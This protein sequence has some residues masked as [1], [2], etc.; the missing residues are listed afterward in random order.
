MNAI[1][2]QNFEIPHIMA[3]VAVVGSG[4][5]GYNAADSLYSLG[6]T[7]VI[8]VTEGRMMGTSRNTGSDK[9]TYYKLNL[10]GGV[11]DSVY[12]MAKALMRGGSMHGDIALTDAALSARGFFKL[13]GLGVP[14]PMNEYGEYVGYK[15]D[16]DETTR[17]TSCG[18][19]TSKYMTEALE[20]AIT[21][22][23][24]PIYDRHRVIKILTENG[25]CKGFLTISPELRT[26]KNPHGLCI[27]S[28]G[29]VV[30]AV[31]GPSAIYADTVYPPSQTCSLGA[32]FMAGAAGA[33]LT[34]SQ[35]GLAS[36]KFRWNLSGTYQ[37]VLPRY[38]STDENGGDE[39]EFLMD[40]FETEEEMLHAIFSKGYEWP[41]DPKKT[42]AGGSSRVDLAVFREKQKG[43]RVFLDYTKNPSPADDNGKLKLEKLS[44]KTREYLANSGALNLATPI[45]RL[46]KMNTPAIK[47]YASHGIDLYTEKLEIAVCAQHC[48]GG[49]AVN[50]NREST[51]LQNFYAVG[52]CAGT[53][54]VY[55]P[56]GS[57]LN[58]T[59]TGSLFAA[60]DIAGERVSAEIPSE[61]S[62]EE[63]RRM[64]V[65]LGAMTGGDMTRDEVLAKRL[66]MGRR[67]SDSAAFLRNALKI[68]KAIGEC[69]SEIFRF[70]DAYRVC[71]ED[72]LHDALINLD[73]LETQLVYLC[74]IRDYIMDDGQS[75]GSYLIIEE[76]NPD[77][78][79]L[80]AEIDTVH[81]SYVQN[82]ILSAP[83][84]V[85]SFFEPVRPLPASEQWFETVWNAANRR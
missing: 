82:T 72:A 47:L 30:Y 31:G 48:N 43:R 15:T 53:F 79:A 28:A 34:E 63:L 21:A 9:Q 55:R 4:A 1:S 41:F 75:R 69:K 54:G 66:A 59:Q 78:L 7:D 56:G 49:L 58:S 76:K 25:I 74:A 71:D 81:A 61:N 46:A 37:Q 13:V 70:T 6:V 10:S 67:M 24:I 80:Q 51:T 42:V 11:R 57:A 35:Y 3:S 12:D 20:K 26:E 23:N 40:A 17:A 44:E 29:A 32:A 39:K 84:M 36:V 73:I 2:I 77:L 83:L 45:E 85:T 27:F 62:L 18:P 64:T 60:I 38:I 5:A 50:N 16:H 8:I 52:E 14:F 19:L 68:E 33:N 22:K 65:M